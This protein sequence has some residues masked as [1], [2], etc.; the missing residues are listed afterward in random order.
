MF[1]LRTLLLSQLNNFLTSVSLILFTVVCK[2]LTALRHINSVFDNTELTYLKGLH[3]PSG[4]VPKNT[5]PMEVLTRETTC[6]PSIS[7]HILR[8]CRFLPSC[9]TNFKVLLF[10]H[11]AFRGFR[12]L[13]SL[14]NTLPP[15]SKGSRFEV[16]GG[17]L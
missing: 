13:V 2:L 7:L 6:N 10:N 8:I 5:G 12:G 11:L 15:R 14:C 9:N 4:S 3:F 16:G 17:R 1:Y